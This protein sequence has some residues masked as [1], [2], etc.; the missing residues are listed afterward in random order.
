MILRVVLWSF[1]QPKSWENLD[2]KS[3]GWQ[4]RVEDIAEAPADEA[5]R[6]DGNLQGKPGKML[7]EHKPDVN[8]KITIMYREDS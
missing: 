8:T 6:I 2:G 3:P 4:W 7:R 5:F 1:R